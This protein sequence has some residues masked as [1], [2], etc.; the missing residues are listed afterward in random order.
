V[1]ALQTD[2]R[3]AVHDRVN[4]R[5]L[6]PEDIGG[7]VDLVVADLSFISITK[8]LPAIHRILAPNGQAVVLVKPQFEVGRD[9]VGHGGVVRDAGDRAAAIEAVGASAVALGFTVL[10][11]MDSPVAGARSGNVEHFLHLAR[12]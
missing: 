9:R 4:V 11:G 1:W 5:S 6:A 3:V 7:P 2:P 12:C 8:V 10:G